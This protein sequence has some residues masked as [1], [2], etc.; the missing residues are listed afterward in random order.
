MTGSVEKHE[1]KTKRKNQSH[2][3][4]QGQGKDTLFTI[5]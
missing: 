3:P 5:N 4:V 1:Y 2:N